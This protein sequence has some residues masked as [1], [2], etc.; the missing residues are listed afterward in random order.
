MDL[1]T[2]GHRESPIFRPLARPGPLLRWDSSAGL[3]LCT[4]TK[5]GLARGPYA[6]SLQY[7]LPVVSPRV[8]ASFNV[9]TQTLVSYPPHWF[10]RVAGKQRY[11]ATCVVNCLGVIKIPAKNDT[12]GVS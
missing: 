11:K 3:L 10:P 2:R 8:M 5:V 4:S 7:T 12:I 9:A 1:V 6:H